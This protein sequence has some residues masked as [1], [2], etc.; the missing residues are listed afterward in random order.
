MI[1]LPLLLRLAG[2]RAACGFVL[3]AVFAVEKADGGEE[4]GVGFHTSPF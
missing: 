1:K 4:L 3:G 2:A